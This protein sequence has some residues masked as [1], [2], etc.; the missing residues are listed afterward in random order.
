MALG[1]ILTGTEQQYVAMKDD[2]GTWRVL[3]TWHEDLKQMNAD[4]DI[5]DTSPAVSVLSEGQ[6]IALIKEAASLGVLQNA[7]S[8]GGDSELESIIDEKEEEIRRLRAAPPIDT[9]PHSEEYKLKEKAMENILKLVS[10]QDMSTLS[11][12]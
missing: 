11:R 10:I 9:T 12:E 7:T 5:D 2:K 8:G 6:F 4:D 3:N 1:N